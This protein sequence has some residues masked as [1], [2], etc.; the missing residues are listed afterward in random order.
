MIKTCQ[1]IGDWYTYVNMWAVKSSPLTIWFL[2]LI[3]SIDPKYTNIQM[4]D[5]PISFYKVGM[6]RRPRSITKIEDMKPYIKGEK[7]KRKKHFQEFG[8]FANS[9]KSTSIST[10]NILNVIWVFSRWLL[11][12][13]NNRRLAACA[14][15]RPTTLAVISRKTIDYRQ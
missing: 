14:F 11:N 15:A 13:A 7:K 9:G 5:R 3:Y 2:Y 12:T 4:Y 6:I 8:V 1:R 10:S